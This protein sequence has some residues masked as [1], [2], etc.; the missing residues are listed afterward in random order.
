MSHLERTILDNDVLAQFAS[1]FGCYCQFDLFGLENSYYQFGDH[2]DY[3]SDATRMNSI[4]RLVGE[5]DRG[6]RVLMAHDIH[7][8]HRLVR[9][10]DLCEHFKSLRSSLK[11]WDVG[12]SVKAKKIKC[13]ISIHHCRRGTAA[14]ASPTSWRTL[15][16]GC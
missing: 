8:K 15:C 9:E 1:E 11:S 14:T 10:L 2:I 7:T 16:L 4:A 12:P 6:D 5:E 13:T 3:P